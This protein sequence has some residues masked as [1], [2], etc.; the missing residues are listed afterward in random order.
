VFDRFTEA[1]KRV[2]ST[3][4][5]EARQRNDVVLGTEHI[6][7]GLLAEPDS[8]AVQLLRSLGASR[9]AVRSEVEKQAGPGEPGPGVQRMPFTTSAKEV[10][11]QAMTE[12]MN[13]SDRHIGTEHLLLGL[14]RPGA[15]H[16]AG[17]ALG[18]LGITADSI[19]EVVATHRGIDEDR[20]PVV[21]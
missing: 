16:V 17:A 7:L 20:G 14:F 4:R 12:A 10:L 5:K 13:F 9:E 11:E 19:R 6:L 3:A 2:L 18:E 15:M 21:L 1:A 8:Y